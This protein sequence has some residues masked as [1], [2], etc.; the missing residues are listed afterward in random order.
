[1]HEKDARK[2]AAHAA[3]KMQVYNR[4]PT[5]LLTKKSSI[6]Q[7]F[8]GQPMKNF[9]GPFRSPQVFKYKEK[10]GKKRMQCV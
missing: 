1:M 8:P 10:T 6:F 2:H 9:A 7:D 4:V 5:L 3:A